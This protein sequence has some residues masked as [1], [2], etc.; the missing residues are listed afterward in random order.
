MDMDVQPGADASLEQD[1]NEYEAEAEYEE[2]LDQESEAESPTAE[3]QDLEENKDS[4][5]ERIDR[6]TKYRRGAEREAESLRHQWE[7]A[8]AE[9]EQLR[10]QQ[11]AQK[12]QEA[13]KKGLADFDYDE[14][15]FTAY[16]REEAATMARDAAR[17]EA[18]RIA[19][20]QRQQE[21]LAAKRAKF[22]QAAD[23]FAKDQA[24]FYEVTQDRN[25]PITQEMAE[26]IM[27]SDVG[28]NVA[29]YLAKHPEEAYQIAGS[30]PAMQGRQ[31]ALI[32]TKLK[33]ELSKQGK[34]TTGAPPPPKGRVKGSEPGFKV[35]PTDAASDKMSD[36]E[37]VLRREAQLAKRNG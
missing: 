8:Q 35:N 16:L 32:E 12:S 2:G 18:Q 7:Q 23:K 14:A 26:V 33:A 31:I 4:F 10:Q 29:Y 6:L 28:P 11:T 22:D 3:D 37:W 25:L 17:T 34:K 30:H 20:E 19:Q 15:Q 13:P 5:Q 21:Q 24:D 36:R 27:D 1:Q 9:L